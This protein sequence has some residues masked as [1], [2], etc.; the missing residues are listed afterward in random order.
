MV[1]AVSVEMEEGYLILPKN[2]A[3]LVRRSLDEAV[4]KT[5]MGYVVV[6][7]PHPEVAS[8]ASLEG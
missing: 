5:L 8:A 2:E 1:P 4:R 6:R 7:A 3:P